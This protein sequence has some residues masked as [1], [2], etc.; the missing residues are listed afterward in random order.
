[1]K[2]IIQSA[3]ALFLISS[4]AACGGGGSA[5]AGTSTVASTSTFSVD[6]AYKKNITTPR[7]LPWTISGV[8]NGISV[9]GSGTVN[10]TYVNSITFNGVIAQV[11]TAAFNGTLTAQGQ[12]SPYVQ[13]ESAYYDSL[14]RIIGSSGTQGVSYATTNLTALPT[15]AKVGDQGNLSSSTSYSNAAKTAIAGTASTTWAISADTATTALLKLTSTST[16]A[17]TVE[18]L[19][20]TP[21]GDVTRLSLDANVN[22]QTLKFSF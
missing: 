3:Q 16:G 12:S 8:I 14:F 1:M 21:A 10:E 11:R 2:K 7:N 9:S 19:R 13:T 5:P 22:G 15:T 18:T 20:I 4:L 6:A 17:T